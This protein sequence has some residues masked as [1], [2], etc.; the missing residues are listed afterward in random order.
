MSIKIGDMVLL[1][2][3]MEES[4]AYGLGVR[5]G[6]IGVVTRRSHYHIYNWIVDFPI[7]ASVHCTTSYLRK[8][9]P[10]EAGRWDYC[11]WKPPHMIPT[12]IPMLITKEEIA[13]W[14]LNEKRSK[15]KLLLLCKG[16]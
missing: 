11:V 1:I 12:L 2:N 6:M 8:I 10:P 3:I 15:R 4:S 9:D 16:N 13:E 14:E 5:K 7:L